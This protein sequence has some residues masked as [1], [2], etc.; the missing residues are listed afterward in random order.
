MQ[1]WNGFVVFEFP[2]IIFFPKG[3]QKKDFAA[4]RVRLFRIPRLNFLSSFSVT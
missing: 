2:S 3:A 4:S 1:I